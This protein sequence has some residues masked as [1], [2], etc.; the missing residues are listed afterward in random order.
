VALITGLIIVGLIIDLGGVPRQERIGFRYWDNPGALARAG[1]SSNLSTDRFIAFVSVLIQAAYSFSGMEVVVIAASETENPRTNIKRAI[2]RV[3]YRILIF[4]VLGILITG[5]LVPYNDPNLLQSTGTAAQSPYVIAM[6]RAGIK[7]LPSIVNAA[8]FTS[9]F[10]AANSYI[11]VSSRV[12]YG[13]AL[14]GHA[15]KVFAYC[16][17]RG[18]PILAVGVACAFAFLAFMNIASGSATVFNWMVDLT[19]VGA[20][21]SWFC[22]NLTW[23]FFDRGLR[24]QG[25]DPKTL[26]YRNRLQ[27]YLAYWGC[28]FTGLVTLINGFTVFWQWNTSKFI[29]SY[30]NIPLFVVFYVGFKLIKRTKFWKPE[31]MDFNTGIPSLEETETVI[32]QPRKGVLGVLSNILV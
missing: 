8:I 1:L 32:D 2:T 24:A 29:V 25:I 28:F 21:I 30:L 15:P 27:P 5:M 20:F 18:V 13:L 12:L 31:E 6:T 10:S 17:K 9:A 7:V 11:F 19:T 22:M 26:S 23:I 16:T 4:Y 3:F 14:R